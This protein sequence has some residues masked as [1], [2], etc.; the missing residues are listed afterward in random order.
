MTTNNDT[1]FFIIISPP[2]LLAYR[3][4]ELSFFRRN[5]PRSGLREPGKSSALTIGWRAGGATADR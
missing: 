4:V 1:F 3:R 2:I 5:R